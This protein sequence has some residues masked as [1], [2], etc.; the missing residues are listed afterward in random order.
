MPRGRRRYF[1]KKF[2]DT[3]W[4]KVSNYHYTKISCS[5]QLTYSG[6]NIT[7]SISTANHIDLLQALVSCPDWKKY[8]A[9]FNSCK[10][11]AMKVIV[12]P[13]SAVGGFLGGTSQI[14]FITGADTIDFG[15]IVESNRSLVLPFNEQKS[16][17]VS[18]GS[19]NTGWQTTGNPV[20]EGKLAAGVSGASSSG[21]M[22]WDINIDFYILFKTEL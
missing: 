7:F 15:E 18:F 6:G 2:K 10:I 8:A 21:A 3:F 5:S 17:Y 1:K 11:R 4:K 16:L 13:H 20:F 9:I 14:A 19:G 12:N 22:N